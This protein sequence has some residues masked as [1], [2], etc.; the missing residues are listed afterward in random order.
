MYSSSS[1]SGSRGKIRTTRAFLGGVG[2]ADGSLEPRIRMPG[3]VPHNQRLP[4]SPFQATLSIS[5]GALMPGSRLTAASTQQNACSAP[6]QQLFNHLN[7]PG[8]ARRRALSSSLSLL[9]HSTNLLHPP[10]LSLPPCPPTQNGEP[11]SP[12]CC[13]ESLHENASNR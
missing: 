7:N 1:S 2:G 3:S 5:G 13:Q 12:G 8:P 10:L 11:C 4:P 6:P 9:L